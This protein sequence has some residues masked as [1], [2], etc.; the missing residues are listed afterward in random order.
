MR[1]CWSVA[2]PAQAH[3]RNRRR[4]SIWRA[5]R[6]PLAHPLCSPSGRQSTKT[7]DAEDV[8]STDTTDGSKEAA[9]E[10]VIFVFRSGRSVA[11]K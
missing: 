6:H 1:M 7:E 5:E 3:S 11:D 2:L 10:D 8:S 4:V 9:S